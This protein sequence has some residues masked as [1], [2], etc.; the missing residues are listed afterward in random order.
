MRTWDMRLVIDKLKSYPFSVHFSNLFLSKKTDL[1][2]EIWS[3][4]P[5]CYAA[6]NSR[7]RRIFAVKGA[8]GV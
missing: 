5:N 1:C 3:N 7:K 8:E 6:R 4:K 2:A